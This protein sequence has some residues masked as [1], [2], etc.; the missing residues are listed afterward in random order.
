VKDPAKKVTAPNPG[1]IPIPIMC[2]MPGCEDKVPQSPDPF[3]RTLLKKHHY[4]TELSKQGKRP[5]GRAL[6][7]CQIC[8][9]I[10]DHWEDNQ[11]TTTNEV[12]WPLEINF[13]LIPERITNLTNLKKIYGMVSNAFFLVN[14]VAWETFIN[15]LKGAKC[16]L[17]DFQRI[18]DWGKFSAVGINAHAG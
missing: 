7:L 17:A 15:L 4:Q 16:N 3:L 18:T 2:P 8:I 9:A 1:E 6:L 11:D 14:S 12:G 13:E 5:D 10:T